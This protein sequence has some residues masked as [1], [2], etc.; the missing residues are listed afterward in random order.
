MLLEVLLNL[1]RGRERCAVIQREGH[2][3]PELGIA[4]PQEDERRVS[5]PGLWGWEQHPTR[6]E[7]PPTIDE[8]LDTRTQTI[9]SYQLPEHVRAAILRRETTPASSRLQSVAVKFK[10]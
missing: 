1:R 2:T 3:R 7:A 8:P 5:L 10:L 9:L 6:A 4:H